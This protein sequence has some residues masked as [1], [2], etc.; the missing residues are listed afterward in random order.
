VLDAIRER[1]TALVGQGLGERD[2]SA[3]RHGLG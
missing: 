1:W 3:A 2:V